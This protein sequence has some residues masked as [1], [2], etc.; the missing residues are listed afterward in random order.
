MQTKLK[1]CGARLVMRTDVQQTVSRYFAVLCQLRQIRHVI[2]TSTFQTLV[3]S[4]VLSRLHYGNAV[5][6]GLPPYLLNHL[7]SVLNAA[8]RLIFGLR[9]TDHITEALVSLHWLRAPQRIH[10]KVAVLAYKVLNRSAPQYLGPLVRI[11]DLPGRR[12]LRSTACSTLDI[13]HFRLTM[14]GSRAFPVAA[15][16]IWNDLPADVTSSPSL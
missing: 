4:L 2:P 7:Q 1:S 11:A 3:V 9:D 8:A 6:V 5:L 12:P 13:L 14:I 15:S 16:R 10:F